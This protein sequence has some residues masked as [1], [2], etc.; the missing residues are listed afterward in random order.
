MLPIIRKSFV[1]LFVTI[2][3]VLS[4]NAQDSK[5]ADTKVELDG[6]C[7]VAYLV[8]EESVKG[9]SKYSS[10]YEGETYYLANADA[11]K[12]FDSDPEKYLPKYDGYCATA[13][14]MGKKMESDP[15]IFSVYN[16]ATYLF[17]NQMAKDSFDK[18]PMMTIKNADKNF[19]ALIN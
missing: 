11:K 3:M 8:M 19:A 17:S 7:P 2:S 5:S 9:D 14:A 12:M 13:V 16:G 4:I 10:T 1:A 6:Y 15:E 18:D